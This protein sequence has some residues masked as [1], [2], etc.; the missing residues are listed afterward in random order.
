M[1]VSVCAGERTGQ[2]AS[3]R[4]PNPPQSLQEVGSVM[5]EE[6][7]KRARVRSAGGKKG[8]RT[9]A[10]KAQGHRRRRLKEGRGHV[11]SAS[12]AKGLGQRPERP[13]AR[14]CEREC[15]LLVLLQQ[16]SH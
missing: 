7:S 15:C 10:K 5:S 16:P 4:R 3:L 13:A 14:A 12:P 6:G 8:G 11:P 9:E 2:D 1:D